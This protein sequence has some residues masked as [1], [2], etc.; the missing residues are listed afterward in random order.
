M[1]IAEAANSTVCTFAQLANEWAKGVKFQWIIVD[2]ATK[3]TDAQMIQPWHELELMIHIGDHTHLGPTTLS[4]AD[5]NLLVN[6]IVHS[7]FYRFIDDG[8]ARHL[9]Q[10]GG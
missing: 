9:V 10:R 3:M 5:K 6:Q 7:P 2:E 8:T 4:K 1:L